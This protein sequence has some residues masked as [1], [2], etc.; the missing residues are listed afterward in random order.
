MKFWKYGMIMITILKNK[1]G[2]RGA[3][4]LTTDVPDDV[5]L[6][7]THLLAGGELTR[8]LKCPFCSFRN[9]HENEI[10]HHIKYK[11]DDVHKAEKVDKIDKKSYIVDNTRQEGKYHY[12]KKEDLPLSR[13]KC[14]WCEYRDKVE[15]DLSW[16]FLEHHRDKLYQIVIPSVEYKRLQ[17]KDPFYY[18]YG[19]TEHILDEAVRLAKL[20]SGTS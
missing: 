20:E 8:L 6:G 5:V 9:I 2:K 15:R 13:I 17:Q 7:V 1:Y 14:L 12:E 16:H 11:E 10:R 3:K 18:L 4:K 19:R